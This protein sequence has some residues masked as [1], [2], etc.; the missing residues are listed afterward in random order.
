MPMPMRHDD[1]R[2]PAVLIVI[3]A[4]LLFGEQYS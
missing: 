4:L 1:A 2:V 3:A